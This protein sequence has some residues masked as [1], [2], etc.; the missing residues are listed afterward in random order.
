MARTR[1]FTLL[2]LLIV[3]ALVSI[4][5]AVATWGSGQLVRGWQLERA[6]QQLYEDLKSVQGRAELSGRQTMNQGLLV[7]Q[8]TFLVFDP[9]EQSYM[10]YHWR[11]LDNDGVTVSAETELL[12]ERELPPGIR[13]GWG[14]EINRRACSNVVG[15]PGS[16]VSFASPAYPPCNG[17]PCIKFDQNGFSSIGPGTLYLQDS[18][19]SL[20]L[21]ATRPGYFTLCEWNGQLW[22]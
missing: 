9:A 2:E 8:R 16:A 1:G 7:T 3:I 15:A 10:A 17:R 5:A 19:Q 14:A 18:D 12:W 20:A 22:R 21:S 11:D 4:M 13:F 6:G